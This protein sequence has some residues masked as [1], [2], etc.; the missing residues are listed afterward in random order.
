M[1]HIPRASAPASFSL[2]AILVL[3]ACAELPAP[4][5]PK[6]PA[7]P[8]PRAETRYEAVPFAAIPGWAGAELA[9]GLAAFVKGCPRI[10][11]GNP[12]YKV[13]EAARSVPVD[14]EAVA[15]RFVEES[16]SAWA[17]LAGDSAA[18]GLV[19]GYYEPILAGSRERGARFR[20]PV[21]GVP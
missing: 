12:L 18:E 2:A 14:E 21:Y 11:P 9:P 10:S 7:P 19:T 5:C 17:V 16:F 20:F 1:T 6:C 15:R 3:A 8:P 4:E 13:C